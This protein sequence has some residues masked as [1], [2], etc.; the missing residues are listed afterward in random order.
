MYVIRSFQFY[1]TYIYVDYF[2]G[3]VIINMQN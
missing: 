3:F 1:T 2:G